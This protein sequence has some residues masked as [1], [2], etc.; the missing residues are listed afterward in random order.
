MGSF[1]TLN[2]GILIVPYPEICRG[3]QERQTTGRSGWNDDVAL[4]R[5][6]AVRLP[7]QG[8]GPSRAAPVSGELTRTEPVIV[9]SYHEGQPPAW[10]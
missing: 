6:V 10:S 1:S 7:F 3:N 8:G 2:I 9:Q 4:C 5:A